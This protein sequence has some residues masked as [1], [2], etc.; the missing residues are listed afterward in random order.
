MPIRFLFPVTLPDP[1]R[2]C[3]VFLNGW[4][5]RK[6][7]VM[8]AVRQLWWTSVQ[9]GVYHERG[10]WLKGHHSGMPYWNN[11]RWVCSD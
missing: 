10:G 11:K 1:E 5:N 4:D 2:F 8:M 3:A 6:A 9:S 7:D